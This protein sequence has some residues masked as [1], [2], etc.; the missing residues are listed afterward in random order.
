[1]K[2]FFRG[3][4]CMQFMR[5]RKESVASIIRE[6]EWTV[7]EHRFARV[8]QDQILQM[9]IDCSLQADR[10][11]F[12][13][14]TL[15]EFGRKAVIR[16]IRGVPEMWESAEL[17]WMPGRVKKMQMCMYRLLQGRHLTKDRFHRFGIHTAV[18]HVSCVGRRMN[19]CLICFLGVV[20][21]VLY[22]GRKS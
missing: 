16:L 14:S 2:G 5:H 17:V 3:S 12:D 8:F 13:G 11:M 22:G 1:M 15:G 18:I 19:L 4:V 21:L 7:G 10:W 9:K 20:L 6:D